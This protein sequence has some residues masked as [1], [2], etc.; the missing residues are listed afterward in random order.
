MRGGGWRRKEKKEKEEKEERVSR[1][2]PIIFR[3]RAA[4]PPG[5]RI[6]SEP[7]SEAPSEEWRG[8]GGLLR[9]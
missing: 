7:P 5:V 3:A 8:E 4:P 1:G 2:I 9:S 6:L